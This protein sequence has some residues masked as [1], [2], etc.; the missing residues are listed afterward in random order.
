MKEFFKGW[1][2]KVGC[3]TLLMA[4]FLTGMWI[5][6]FKIFDN[7]WITSLQNRNSLS[8]S[9]GCIRLGHAHANEARV[10]K[11]DVKYDS[12]VIKRKAKSASNFTEHDFS[13]V[14][15]DFY[16][17]S[18]THNWGHYSDL[19]QT[20]GPPISVR[21]ISAQVPYWSIVIPLTLL[22][23]WLLISKSRVAKP[24]PITEPVPVEGS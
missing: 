16:L 3:V 15:G 5:R 6:S 9:D 13:R 24:K 8:S 21:L 22:S 12:H 14:A 10:T 2:R 4:L 19:V 1:R 18:A 17:K 23:A 20:P 7:F 11:W